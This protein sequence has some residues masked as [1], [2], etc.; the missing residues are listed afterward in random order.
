MKLGEVGDSRLVRVTYIC[1]VQAD[2]IKIPSAKPNC[3]EYDVDNPDLN[4]QC[5]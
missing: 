5:F 1:G 3:P 2:G 4:N